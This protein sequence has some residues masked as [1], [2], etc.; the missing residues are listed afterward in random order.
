MNNVFAGSSTVAISFVGSIAV[1][2]EFGFS[3]FAGPIMSLFGYKPILWA[4]CFFISAGLLIASWATQFWHLYVTQGVMFGTG[5]SFLFMAA[6]SIPPLWFTKRQG[7]AMGIAASGSGIGGL[8]L[9]PIARKLLDSLGVA[10]ALRV[11]AIFE[12]VSSGIAALLLRAPR[13]QTASG[14]KVADSGK[15]RK[16]LDFSVWKEKG[17]VLWA[18]SAALF[19]FGYLIPFSYI[20]AYATFVG[21]TTSDGAILV[22]VM[23]GCN[24]VGRIGIGFLGDRLGRINVAAICYLL[25]GISCLAIWINATSYGVLMLFSVI[26]GL[27]S[28]V[29]FSLAAPITG[30]I[31]VGILTISIMFSVVV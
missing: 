12:L 20:P 11:V 14:V 3:I 10:W 19:T 25:S 8:V 16:A 29:F 21:L 4:G 7:L 23:S 2:A 9:S 13:R 1:S 15:K 18:C 24:A 6:S 28:G 30:K 17:F 27:F 26:Y 31:T 22:S 5:A